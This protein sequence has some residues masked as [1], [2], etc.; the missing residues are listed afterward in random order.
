MKDFIKKHDDKLEPIGWVLLLIGT[1]ITNS[2]L[3]IS[4]S[5]VGAMLI[6]CSILIGG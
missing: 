3:R 2:P 1:L 6:V 5:V 4:A